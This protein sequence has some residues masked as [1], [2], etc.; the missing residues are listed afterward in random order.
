MSVAT[1]AKGHAGF[2]E[3]Q[4]QQIIDVALGLFLKIRDFRRRKLRHAAA[5]QCPTLITVVQIY[6][7]ALFE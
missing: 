1:K 2:F 5:I 7:H 3:P 6:D 4:A